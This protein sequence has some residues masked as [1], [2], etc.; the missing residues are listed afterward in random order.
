MADVL[1]GPQYRKDPKLWVGI[2]VKLK[3]DEA[4]RGHKDKRRSGIRIAAKIFGSKTL[5]RVDLDDSRNLFRQ[6]RYDSGLIR[7]LKLPLSRSYLQFFRPR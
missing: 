4:Q 7:E 2:C 3:V 6:L 1:P 5:L